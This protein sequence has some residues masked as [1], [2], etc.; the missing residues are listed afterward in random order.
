MFKLTTLS[1]LVLISWLDLHGI[2]CSREGLPQTGDMARANSPEVGRRYQ[3]GDAVWAR[4]T[5]D[6]TWYPGTVIQVG[7]DRAGQ[8]LYQVTYAGHPHSW[9]E[10]LHRDRLRPR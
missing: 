7:T 2:F 8:D 3:A 5:K 10:W 4:R 6:N 9:D 1:A